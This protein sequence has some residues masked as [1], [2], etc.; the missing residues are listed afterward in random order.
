MRIK[1]SVLCLVGFACFS[2]LAFPQAPSGVFR[3]FDYPG[4]TNTQPTAIT[5]YGEIVGGYFNS[6][7]IRHAFVLKEGEFSSLDFPGAVTTGVNWIKR[8]VTS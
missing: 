1:G 8:E 3:S 5:A 4:A 6:D 2:A 7:G